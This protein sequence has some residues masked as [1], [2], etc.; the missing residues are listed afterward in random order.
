MNA[1][2]IKCSRLALAVCACALLCGPADAQEPNADALMKSLRQT[3]TLQKNKDIQGYIYIRRD[4]VKV[5]F[6]I[7]LRGELMCFQYFHNN[8]WERFDLKFKE[9][10]QELQY[11]KDG[12]MVT[13]PKAMYST[14]IPKTDV[15]YEDLSMRFLYWPNGQVLHEDEN[16]S[17]VMGRLCWIVQLKNPTPSLGQ[18]AW[19]RVWI[20]KENGGMLQIDGIDARGELAKRFLLTSVMKL[21]DG[22]WFF[23]E[24]KVQVRDKN[25][26]RKTVANNYIRMNSP[27]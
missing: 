3:A 9:R 14:P 24:M 26:S 23:K 7:S 12:K 22:A 2:M 17:T 6:S 8:V 4:N 19:M 21:K 10:G 15:T 16:T 18:Y 5:P 25:D 27:E 11:Q 13:L 1:L 20:D